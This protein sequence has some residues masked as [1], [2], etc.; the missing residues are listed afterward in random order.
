MALLAATLNWF[1]ARQEPGARL[2]MEVESSVDSLAQLFIA[3]DKGFNED[4]KVERFVHRGTSPQRLEFPLPADRTIKAFR[5]DP[6][7]TPG[8]VRVRHA[9]IRLDNGREAKRFEL[10]LVLP[11]FA[12]QRLTPQPGDA[13]EVVTEPPSNDPQLLL[14][15]TA[16]FLARYSAGERVSRV[17]R[18]DAA[19]LLLGLAAGLAVST[20]HRWSPGLRAGARQ[21]GV[22][23]DRVADRLSHPDFIR[24]D[25]LAVGFYAA[26]LA[27][28]LLWSVPGF[29]G[30]SITIFDRNFSV[31]SDSGHV[32]L[33]GSPKRVRSDEW[34]CQ[35][36][37]I[38][39]QLLRHDRLAVSDAT[40]GPGKT[41]LLANVPC[42]HFLMI[43]RP[44][45]WPFFVLPLDAAFACYWQAK[46]LLLL[47]GVFTLLLVLTRSSFASAVGS[48]WFY[49]SAFTQWAFS[50]PSGLPEMIGLFGWV[51]ALALFLTVGRDARAL[52]LAAGACAIGAVDFALCTYPPHQIPLVLFGAA[53][54]AGWGWRH[55]AGIF[56]REDAASR[57]A[58][59]GGCGLVVA[60]AMG[61][62]YLETRD[63]LEIAANTVYPGRRSV[64]GGAIS[65][66]WLLSHFLD[67]WK[68]EDFVPP[69]L[70]NICEGTGYLWFA[71]VLLLVGPRAS[72]RKHLTPG[73][74]EPWLW[75]AFALL[76]A[77]MVL[78]VPA[79][80][81][82]WVF[83]HKVPPFRAFHALGLINVA[84]VAVY[85]AR[86]A[87]LDPAATPRPGWDGQLVSLVSFMCTGGL[88]LHL[89]N[90]SLGKF[91]PPLAVAVCAA[92][93][94]LLLWC[95]RNH[96]P[97]AFALFLLVPLAVANGNVNPLDR[98]LGALRGGTVFQAI[99]RHPELKVGKCLVYAPA[100]G[101]PGLLRG[102][103]LDVFNSVKFVPDLVRMAHFDP[104]GR[105]REAMNQ[106][107]YLIAQPL[108]EGEVSRCESPIQGHQLWKVSPLDPQL[109]AI[110]VRH[111]VFDSQ[112]DEKIL[113]KLRPALTE[114]LP[115]VWIYDV[116]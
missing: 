1:V 11:M 98:G 61:A 74:P 110:G 38:L 82:K 112:P 66:P 97:R 33:L 114:P 35:T 56:R 115:G 92:Y 106:S 58:A 27:G 96:W 57:L 49:L 41:T 51:M 53:I 80:F 79:S 64:D 13:L 36:P 78:P 87:D 62:F 2:E 26:C 46:G 95:L 20:R 52:T 60:V 9:G 71:P 47:T 3:T 73:C 69:A 16:P 28:F 65:V 101:L 77:W 76:A 10:S 111:V 18:L 104:G 84:I 108:P 43:F 8:T 30:S 55:R 4:E 70:I 7:T 89:A 116:P 59:L 68:R 90:V 109:R 93:T 5:Y 14:P 48:V 12:I 54:T 107:G 32:P 81:G 102:A 45:F 40:M 23:L 100:E 42:A 25:R 75:A 63:V 21:T 29:H 24:F 86:M 72:G 15:L 91:F 17:L 34:N 44:Q 88:V 22:G 83:L 103:G 113:P 105:Y 37:I 39:N 67:F 6:L 19:F 31:F 85:L 94:G 99:Q 50:W